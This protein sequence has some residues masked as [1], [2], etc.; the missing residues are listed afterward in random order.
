MG[1][2]SVVAA[3]RKLRRS[4]T[5]VERK[6]WHRIRDKQV[7]D[8]RFRRQR[9]IG[10]YI[11]DFVSLEAKLIIEVDGGQHATREV[12]DAARTIFLE[13]LGYRVVRFWNNE[14]IDDMEGVLERIR[15][16]LLQSAK[17]NPTP[18][19][20]RGRGGSLTSPAP[21]GVERGFRDACVAPAERLHNA[22]ANAPC[23]GVGM[24]VRSTGDSAKKNTKATQ[25]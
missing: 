23:K 14:V 7:E 9:P 18:R 2:R 24:G 3:A 17:S 11:V 20:P 5:G 25:P 4:S 22:V 19:P 21:R 10:K 1:V 8:F 13:S 15:A 12:Q 6:L 16:T